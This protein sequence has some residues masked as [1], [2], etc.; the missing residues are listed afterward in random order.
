MKKKSDFSGPKKRSL[1]DH[2]KHIRQVQS[3]SYYIELSDDERKSFNHFMIL[4]ALSMDADIVEEM[5]Q[6]Y[7]VVDKIPSAQ[8]YKLL[9]AI[10]PKSDKFYP[11]VKSKKLKHNKKILEI[12]SGRFQI[13]SYQANEYVNILLRSEAGS[14][15]LEMILKSTGLSD[16]E[17]NEFLKGDKYE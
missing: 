9:I 1:F 6:L 3:P 13:P 4:R 7:Q 16:K 17:A 2:V 12:V 14:A 10:V 8:F 15:E 5:A 11:W